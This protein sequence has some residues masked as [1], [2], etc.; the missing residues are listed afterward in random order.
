ME[1]WAVVWSVGKIEP[2]MPIE[3]QERR[4]VQ[5][6]KD[7]IRDH[8]GAVFW[9]AIWQRCYTNV[10]AIGYLYVSA[11]RVVKH[12][13]R[14]EKIVRREDVLQ[15]DRP[16]IPPCRDFDTLSRSISTWIKLT[17]IEDLKNPISPSIMRKFRNNELLG[18]GDPGKAASALQGA[19]RIV[20]GLWK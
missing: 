11:E 1:S 14:I 7:F 15:D 16:F 19:V 10:G 13:L 12:R 17:S 8:G 20:D 18:S 9:T 5:L 3:R 2:N 4:N 6:H